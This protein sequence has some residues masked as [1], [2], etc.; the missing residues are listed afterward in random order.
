V[1]KILKLKGEKVVLPK[2][3]KDAC[4]RAGIFSA[5][6]V[7]ENSISVDIQKGK[8]K[9]S[10]EGVTGKHTEIKKVKYDGPELQFSIPPQLLM[11]VIQRNNECEICGLHLKIKIGKFTY[12]TSLGETK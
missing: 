5:D 1:G 10:G 2:G 6:N 8:V 9:I 12:V 11:E 4:E 3:L 7:E